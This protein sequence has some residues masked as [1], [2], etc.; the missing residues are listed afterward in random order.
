MGIKK[1]A[2]VKLGEEDFQRL[3]TLANTQNMSVSA[4]L[5]ICVDGLLNK[6]IEIEKGEL[7]AVNPDGYGVSQFSEEDLAENIRYRE[8]RF[9]KLMGA[10]EKQGYP[11]N[12]IRQSVEQMTCSVLDSPRFNGKRA[13]F[14]EG[15]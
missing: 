4:I 7:K 12:V 9:D 15:C 6:D 8:L 10:F 14:D 11:D 2:G 5:K 1:V 13:R 3:E